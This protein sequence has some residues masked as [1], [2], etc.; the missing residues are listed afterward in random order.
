MYQY[1]ND[2]LETTWPEQ[3]PQL[4]W[5][6]NLGSFKV[7]RKTLSGLG[8]LCTSQMLTHSQNPIVYWHKF[9]LYYKKDHMKE[10]FGLIECFTIMVNQQTKP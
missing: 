3:G 2:Y 10:K 9:S 1:N 8:L 4:K 6:I 5:M 7:A